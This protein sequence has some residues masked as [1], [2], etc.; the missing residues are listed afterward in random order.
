MLDHCSFCGRFEVVT[1]G[2][3]RG[4]DGAICAGCL[5]AATGVADGTA[6]WRAK[7]RIQQRLA[8]RARWRANRR[9][10]ARGLPAFEGLLNV[11]I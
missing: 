4:K 11:A 10:K 7:Q 6:L 3:I 1:G 2:L 9:W 5:H 8:M